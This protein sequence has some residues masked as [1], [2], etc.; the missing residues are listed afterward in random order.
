MRISDWSS[1]VCSS[2]LNERC[3]ELQAPHREREAIL[4]IEAEGGVD[5]RDAGP[6]EPQPRNLGEADV[7][8]LAPRAHG[9]PIDP[10]RGAA[11]DLVDRS[12]EHTSEFQSLMRISYAVFC[13]TKK[14][15]IK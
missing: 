12:D 8:R 15:T 1:D 5:D 11:V 13:L 10:G 4:P 7:E 3:R 6:G 2:D 9:L 14:N